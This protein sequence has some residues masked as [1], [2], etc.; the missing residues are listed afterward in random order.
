MRKNR[1]PGLGI[2]ALYERL[3]RDDDLSGE[4]NSILNQKRYLEDFALQAGFTNLRHYTDDGYTGTNFDRPGF[5]AMMA[6]VEAGN[7][8]TIIVK[9]MSRFGRN[10]IEVGRYTDQLFPELGIRFIAISND[11]DTNKPQGND[12]IPFLNVINDWYAKDTSRKIKTI[13]HNRMSNGERCSGSVPY[14]FIMTGEKG[15][16]H[17][18]IDEEAARVVRRIFDMAADGRTTSEIAEA[19]RNDKVLI[20]MAYDQRTANRQNYRKKIEDPYRWTPA[21][22]LHILNRPDYIGTLVMGKTIRPSFHSKKRVAVPKSQWLVF[23]NAHEAIVDQETWDRAHRLR[24]HATH[25]TPSGTYSNPMSGL[26]VCGDCGSLMYHHHSIRRGKEVSSWQ[27]GNHQRDRSQCCSHYLETPVVEEAVRTALRFVSERVL[28]NPADFARELLDQVTQKNS[29]ELAAEKEELKRLT[30][31]MNELDMIVRDLFEKNRKGIISDR[32]FERMVLTYNEEQNTCEAGKAELEQKLSLTT[33]KKADIRRFLKLIERYKSFEELTAPLLFELIDRIV[34]GKPIAPR[35]KYK[36]QQIDIYFRFVGSIGDPGLE[37]MAE[38]AY[39]E[40]VETKREA[41][42]LARQKRKHKNQ[43]QR[44]KALREA[45][46]AGDPEAQAKL[47]LIRE[48]DRARAR[49]KRAQ[50]REEDPDYEQ[51]AEQRKQARI[52]KALET[53]RARAGGK[54]KVDIYRAA[55]QGDPEAMELAKALKSETYQRAKAA[56]EA[57]LAENPELA[58]V[59][60]AS[61]RD[62]MKKANARIREEYAELKRRA[63]DGDAEAIA[64]VA[65]IR[66]SNN[67]R[68][69]EY[70][71][72]LKEAAQSDPEAAARLAQMK[73]RKNAASLARYHQLKEGAK[74]RSCCSSP[75]C[76]QSPGSE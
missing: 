16:R 45:A 19:L 30:D 48:K 17:F 27:C 75:S 69:K 3:S 1:Q 59:L 31:R 65:E 21:M 6:E 56:Q 70:Y 46:K 74:N 4:S 42:S 50:K 67:R 47:E 55:K 57:R 33:D 18:A 24:K 72:R 52:A 68:Q 10:Y 51:K 35:S 8:S 2:T 76:R 37:E 58:E 63:E 22:V 41:D 12:F 38:E 64:K 54:F 73:E 20:P 62:T 66:A 34:I 28:E 9:D 23:P 40:E 36:R 53:K 26:L 7:I 29:Q 61:K 25:Y 32:Q 43:A 14:G 39:L 15:N 60:K 44:Q 11:F 71:H 5:K 13:F 49:R